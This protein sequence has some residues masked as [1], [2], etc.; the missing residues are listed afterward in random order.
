MTPPE[1][2]H[3][4]MDEFYELYVLGVL[5]PEL[6]AVI[7]AHLAENCEHCQ[8]RIRE[9]LTVTASL[10]SL[11]PLRQPPAALRERVLASIPSA[12][13]VVA[14]PAPP[15]RP[16]AGGLYALS[17]ACAA[18][19]LGCVWLGYQNGQIRT[20]LANANRDR[21]TLEA[22]LKSLSRSETKTVQFGRAD[23]PHGRVFVNTPSGVVFVASSLPKLPAGRTFQLWLIPA[24][25]GPKS[26]GVFQSDA[27]GNSVQLSPVTVDP[28]TKAVAV[29]VEPQNGSPAPTTTPIIIIPLA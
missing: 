14:M 26:A 16:A 3:A 9:A 28:G 5:E 29:S 18:L 24:A 27:Q 8:S 12:R 22:A 15:A 11:A 21:S 6:A 23:Q 25:G 7:D 13:K 1:M 10:A 20:D 19:F 2:N 4:E 17:A